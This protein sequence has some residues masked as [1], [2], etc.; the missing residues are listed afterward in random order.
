MRE[1][2]KQEEKEGKG[3]KIRGFLHA[4]FRRETQGENKNIHIYFV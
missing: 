2:K 1:A 4:N 3:T